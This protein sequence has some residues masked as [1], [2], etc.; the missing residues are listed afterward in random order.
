MSVPWWD[1]LI[2]C[3]INCEVP[4]MIIHICRVVS[5]I[6][7]KKGMIW[8]KRGART[9][10]ARE[11]WIGPSP[12]TW[13]AGK[14]ASNPLPFLLHIHS[15]SPPSHLYKA[16]LRT[17]GSVKILTCSLWQTSPR[18][19]CGRY[20]II[21]R[22]AVSRFECRVTRHFSLAP[23]WKLCGCVLFISVWTVGFLCVWL[24]NNL[25]GDW[26]IRIGHGG[27]LHA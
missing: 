9:S 16:S 1:I 5:L 27:I 21:M 18:G 2:W 12:S 13:R 6:A 20:L 7:P 3:D 23:H 15:H 8:R 10:W 26:R 11:L 14:K 4:S 24:L 25:K 17:L 22:A 19:G